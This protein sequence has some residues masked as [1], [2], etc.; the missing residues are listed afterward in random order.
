MTLLDAAFMTV[1]GN[2]LKSFH[3]IIH[4]TTDI[5]GHLHMP[6]PSA[7]AGVTW[8]DK[9]T[10]YEEI[11]AFKCENYTS[12]TTWIETFLRW[13]SL[14]LTILSFPRAQICY[15]SCLIFA[16][17]AALQTEKP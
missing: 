5:D 10:E 4:Y 15:I 2:L 8:P 12:Q 17:S 16:L 7:R 14:E 3:C 13:P 9:E 1:N 6:A 11:H